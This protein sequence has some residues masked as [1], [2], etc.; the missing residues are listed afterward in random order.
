VGFGAL[1]LNSKE[2][3]GCR[4]FGRVRL[5]PPFLFAESRFFVIRLPIKLRIIK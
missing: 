3:F 4:R 5:N 2:K 1:Q